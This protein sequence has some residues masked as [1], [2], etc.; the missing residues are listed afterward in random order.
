VR[1]GEPILRLV[2]MDRLRVEGFVDAS[3][4]APH[5]LK[6][7]EVKIVLNL[8]GVDEVVLTARIQA[9]S[10]VVEANRYRIWTEVE[11]QPGRGGYK[12]LM[13][14]GA[15]ARMVITKNPLVAAATR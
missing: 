9:V 7:A 15:D 3:M 2:R 8:A 10:S 14:P 11:N 5:Q 12:W 1:A 13:R 6:D 4:V